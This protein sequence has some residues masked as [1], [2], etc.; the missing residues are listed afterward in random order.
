MITPAVAID[1]AIEAGDWPAESI[2]TDLT[3]RAVAA[4]A[5]RLPDL[6][7]GG[8]LSVVFTDD[9]HIATLNAAWRNKPKPTNVLSFPAAQ[10]AGDGGRMLGD[11]VLALETVAR[12][13]ADAHLTLG[14]H[15]THLLVHGLLHLIGYDHESDAEAT[16]ME[17]MEIEILA[18]LGIADP[19]AGSEPERIEV[20]GGSGQ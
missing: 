13:A 20:A 14:D 10:I 1:L 8:E 11:I 18:T 3:E 2:L 19:Y 12:E 15:I 17:A 6:R 7:D 16:A 5:S 9:E 4:A